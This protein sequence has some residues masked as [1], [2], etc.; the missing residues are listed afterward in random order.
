MLRRPPPAPAI[1]YQMEKTPLGSWRRYIH[2]DGSRFAEY[3]SRHSLF[4]LPLM[5]YCQG[6]CP[7]TG[8]RE[9]AR[10]VV[11]VGR[12]AVGVV[13]VGQLS[14]GLIGIG[15]FSL[16][17]LIGIGQLALGPLAAGQVAIGLVALGQLAV[18]V[19]AVGQYGVGHYVLAQMG[20]GEYLWSQHHAD[21]GAQR[22][23]GGVWDWLRGR[24]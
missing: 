10:G 22:F 18:G 4:G 13:A 3:R 24:L 7:E 6:I 9:V 19:V 16:G 5:H 21:P 23:F 20:S 12:L 2:P 15:Q 17:L 14:L 11:A 8:S 1:A